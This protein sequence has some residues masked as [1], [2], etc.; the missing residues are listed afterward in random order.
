MIMKSMTSENGV[1]IP[2]ILLADAF[3]CGLWGSEDHGL[4]LQF[5]FL[6]SQAARS[7][8]SIEYARDLQITGWVRGTLR[9]P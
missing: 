9:A 2:V 5:G 7:A 8:G 4:G 1:K 6:R 3:L